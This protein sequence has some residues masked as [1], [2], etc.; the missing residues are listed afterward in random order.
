MSVIVL[1]YGYGLGNELSVRLA[2]LF[3]LLDKEDN[4]VHISIGDP[5]IRFGVLVFPMDE[6]P[7]LFACANGLKMTAI[8]K[9]AERRYSKIIDCRLPWYGGHHDES[10]MSEEAIG[11]MVACVICVPGAGKGVSSKNV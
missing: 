2:E 4:I 3:I 11:C 7:Q 8:A 1:E 10:E 9:G 5:N 6:E